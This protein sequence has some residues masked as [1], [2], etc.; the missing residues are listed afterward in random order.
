MPPIQYILCIVSEAH[1]ANLL[2]LTLNLM[3]GYV[4]AYEV[5]D[6]VVYCSDGFVVNTEA[7]CNLSTNKALLIKNC[8]T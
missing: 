5:I 1:G 4:V 2:M 7:T 6:L 8:I 3:D